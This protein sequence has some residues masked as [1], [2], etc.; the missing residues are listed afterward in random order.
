MVQSNTGFL[1][2]LNPRTGDTKKIDTGGYLV[3]NGDGIHFRGQTLY[4]VRNQDGL[5]AVLRVGEFLRTR[6]SRA[7]SC[8]RQ[9]RSTCRRRRP[10]RWAG[11]T[12]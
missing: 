8:R 10:S 3:T 2:R 7:R 9:V 5:V 1:F 12:S 4:V 6:D 11:S